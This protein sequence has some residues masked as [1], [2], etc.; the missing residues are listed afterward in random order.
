MNNP[1]SFLGG[2]RDRLLPASI[3]FR[4]FLAAS[5]YHVLAWALLAFAADEAVRFTGGP[6]L[7]LA[8]L[9]L[10]T[11]GVLTMTAVGAS[12]QLLP[13]VTRRPLGRD[14]P[15]RMSF[16][17]LFPGIALLALG[18]GT[19]DPAWMKAGGVL[20][21]LG[22][23][24]YALVTADNLRRAGSLPVVAAHGWLALVALA[25]AVALGLLLIWDFTAGFLGD[26]E[27]VALAHMGLA[28]FGFMGVLAF[29]LSLVLIPMFQLSRSLPARPGWAQ[30]GFTALALAAYAG[31]ILVDLKPLFWL[32]LA[33]ALAA[34]AVYLW[35]MRH[36]HRT[37]MRKRLGLSFL[38]IRTSWALMVLGLV[39][40][41]AVWAGLGLPNGPTLAG[42]VLLA[43]WLLTFLTGVLQR[44]M[45]FLASMHAAGKGGLPPLL[46]ELTAETPLRLHAW[47]HFAALAMCG[48]GITA[49]TGLPVR[50][51]AIVGTVGALA[52][53]LF[54]L[55]VAREVRRRQIPA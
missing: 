54:A 12:Y 17:L 24:I 15:A 31:G 34:S 19:A 40:T 36:I 10:L 49:D 46:S 30:V 37:A 27:G 26:H 16:W 22:L 42:F 52:F 45:P 33:A 51:G 50:L 4:F 47:C 18:M 23:T 11:L 21:G 28:G 29:G 39:L 8:A 25:V 20:A 9:H 7:T 14:W 38:V 41:G 53:A 44:I 2:A 55:N 35:Q 43:G 1:G 48:A 32:G 5:L 6:G 3:P 13:V